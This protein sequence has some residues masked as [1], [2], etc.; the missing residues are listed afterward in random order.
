MRVLMVCPSYPPQEVTCGVGDYT[1]CLAEELTHHGEQITVLCS[2]E[3]RGAARGSV[4]VFP[5]FSRWTL[6]QALRLTFSSAVPRGDILHLQYTPDL[7][8]P[9]AGFKLVPLLARLRRRAPPTVVTFHTLTGRSPWSRIWAVLLLASAHQSISANEEVTAMVRRRL[10][11]L[12]PR[13]TEIPIGTGVP[14]H[15]P[16]GGDRESG[17]RLLGLAPGIPLLVHFGLV[18]PG[19]GL[20]TLF[21]ALGELVRFR[22]SIR[23]AIVGDTRPDSQG[24]RATLEALASRLGVAEAII[25]AGR[26][27]E[28][29]VSKILQAADLFVVPYDDG[30]SIRRGTLMAGLAPGLPVISTTSALRS[31]YLRDGENV[32]L[33][34][35]RDPQALAARIASLLGAPDEAAFL[36]KGARKLAERFT[37]QTIARETRALYARVLRR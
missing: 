20:E 32:A 31:A 27:P 35:P 17:R 8:G 34:P 23:L 26:R 1:R 21:M 16:D 28:E 37:W 2:S 12:S 18:Y 22:S 3:Y 15:H 10:P 29:E 11:K 25:W 4:E 14:V 9:G 30:V 19:K 33:V 13:L 7:Y 36:G 24:Y 6:D 5:R